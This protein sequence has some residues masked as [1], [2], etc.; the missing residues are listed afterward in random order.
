VPPR[1]RSRRPLSRGRTLGLGTPFLVVSATAP[2]LQKWFAG[3]DHPSA[4]DPY[5]LYAANNVGSILALLA[6]PFV[7]E[8]SWSLSTQSTTWSAGYAM[9]AVMTLAC[10]VVAAR[11]NVAGGLG[12]RAGE[13]GLPAKAGSHGEAG[14]HASRLAD[15]GVIAFHIS[16]RHL[17]LAPILAALAGQHGLVALVQRDDSSERARAEGRFPSEWLVMAR[18]RDS[19]GGLAS[20][21]RW[22]PPVAPGGTRVWTDDFSDVLAVLKTNWAN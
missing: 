4:Q 7:V 20:D 1:E 10:A 2:L 12:V 21:R 14:S 5:R 18:S 9:F 16:N 15:D 13:V 6:Y 11:R 22:T 3:T 17:Q 8:P 19:L